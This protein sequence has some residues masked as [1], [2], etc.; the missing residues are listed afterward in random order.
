MCQ[1]YVGLNQQSTKE[2]KYV[3]LQMA[4]EKGISNTVSSTVEREISHSE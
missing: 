1:N 3:A 2:E 4:V